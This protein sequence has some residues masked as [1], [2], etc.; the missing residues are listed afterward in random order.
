MEYEDFEKRYRSDP[1]GFHLALEIF[2]GSGRIAIEKLSDQEL[3]SS[4]M[5]R[6][7]SL[8]ANERVA[9]VAKTARDLAGLKTMDLLSY[10]SRCGVKL[11]DT[12]VGEPGVCPLCGGSLIYGEDA[13]TD[14]PHAVGW[15]CENCG[16]T[17]KEMYREVFDCHYGV[18]NSEG[19]L[20]LHHNKKE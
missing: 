14:R 4:A 12:T 18:R 19:A 6:M 2:M 17:G 3:I 11:P 5:S 15:T 1:V 9:K 8:F 20:V 10:A 13:A 7:S 16:A